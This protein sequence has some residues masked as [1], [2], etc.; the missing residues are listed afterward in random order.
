MFDIRPFTD[1]DRTGLRNIYV[2]ARLQALPWVNRSAFAEEDFDTDTRGED[3]L[4]A[5]INTLPVGFIALNPSDDRIHHLYVDPDST[6]RGVGSAL[7]AASI[8]RLGRPAYLK[9]LIDNKR[10]VAF[11]QQRGW[12]VTG[13][14]EDRHGR[15]YTM[16]L[17]GH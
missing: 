12:Q 8:E 2:A 13:E 15:Y 5:T 17:K 9:C 7:L 11:Y 4:V 1:S 6:G 3:L 14:G 16:A 10:A